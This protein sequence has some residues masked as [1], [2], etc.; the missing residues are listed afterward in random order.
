MSAFDPISGQCQL[1]LPFF[2]FKGFPKLRHSS[3]SIGFVWKTPFP[4][5]IN[6]C[7]PGQYESNLQKA[8]ERM[9]L[10]DSSRITKCVV[11][12]LVT[13]DGDNTKS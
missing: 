9:N 2:L 4:V 5:Q 11:G 13:L 8:N 1:F 12:E 3:F 10:I 7:P 6:L